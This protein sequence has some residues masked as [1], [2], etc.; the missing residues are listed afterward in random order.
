MKSYIKKPERCEAMQIGH[1]D[2]ERFLVKCQ[3]GKVTVSLPRRMFD[4]YK[5]QL[6]DYLVRTTEDRT[7]QVATGET[8]ER[9]DRTGR[10][11]RTRI[12][13]VME[14]VTAQHETLTVMKP[15]EFEAC[16][17]EET[18]DAEAP[19]P[20]PKVGGAGLARVPAQSS[21]GNFP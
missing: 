3:A 17:I 19:P 15:A 20:D 2:R 7:H 16:W 14:A 8:V 10:G 6:G 11:V 13:P 1:I 21:G 12:Y 5:P 4:R 9:Q 18:E